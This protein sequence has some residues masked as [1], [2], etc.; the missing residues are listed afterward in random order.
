M[1]WGV[2]G[3]GDLVREAREAAGLSKAK[4]ALALGVDPTIIGRV[5]REEIG[6]SPSVFQRLVGGILPSLSAP[7]LLVAMGYPVTVRGA[8]R[9]PVQLVRDLLRLDQDELRAI[10][11]LVRKR[12]V[13]ERPQS[14]RARR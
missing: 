7:D 1:L 3:Y 4:L 6:I 10:A 12:S 14:V 8:E 2:A 9:L 11:I 13:A 5:E